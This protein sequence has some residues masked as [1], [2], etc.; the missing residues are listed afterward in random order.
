[1]IG[2]F[3]FLQ[4]AILSLWQHNYSSRGKQEENVIGILIYNVI[5]Y[6]TPKYFKDY[7]SIAIML[8]LRKNMVIELMRYDN[9]AINN[10]ARIIIV[11]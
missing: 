9:E 8:P 4:R 6:G 1:M 7:Y 10:V 11:H 3:N 5:S 2:L